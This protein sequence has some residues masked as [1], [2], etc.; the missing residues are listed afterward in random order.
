M[1]KMT[2]SVGRRTTALTRDQILNA[3][4]EVLDTSGEQGLTF[5]ALA[6]RLETGHGA[7]QW[8]VANKGELLAAATDRVMDGVFTSLLHGAAPSDT[9]RALA[10]GIFDTIDAHPWV[11][12][13]LASEPSQ[14]SIPQIFEV[15]GQSLDALGVAAGAQFD[16]ASVIVNYILGVAGQNASNVRSHSGGPDRH[17]FLEQ[18]AARW[19]SFDPQKFPF[20]HR[21]AGE[22][23]D[24]DD[25][26]QY[27]DGIDLILD[28]IAAGTQSN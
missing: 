2:R 22:L 18:A 3:A 25:R 14:T 20:L 27:L 19:A 24:H 6:S 7:I 12:V 16:N 9:I 21:V 15:T 23:S 11:G 4:T 8:H 1:Q 17:T 10:L 28:G 5:R 26:A 13:Q